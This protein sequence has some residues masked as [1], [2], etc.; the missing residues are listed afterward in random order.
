M[1]SFTSQ[2]ALVAVIVG[3]ATAVAVL[4]RDRKPLSLRY[5]AFSLG[6][7]L[8]FLVSFLRTLIRDVDFDGWHMASASLVLVGGTAF[9]QALLSD[10]GGRAARRGRL[11]WLVA[12]VL[13]VLAATPLHSHL[14]I[15]VAAAVLAL[16]ILGSLVWTMERRARDVESEVERWRLRTVTVG[17]VVVLGAVVVDLVTGLGVPLPPPGGIATAIYLYFMSQSLVRRRLLDLHEL[18]AKAAVFSALALTLAAVY[19]VLVLWASAPGVFVFNTL[20]ASAI[21]LI[22]YDPVRA[23]LEETF[24]RTFFA[25]QRDFARTLAQQSHSLLSLVDAEAVQTR[26]LDT[27]YNSKRA[28]HCAFYLLG[29]S[30]LGLT[31]SSFR[32]PRP[33]NRLE[34]GLERVLLDA[35]QADRV[36]LQRD[37]LQDRLDGH[38]LVD[39]RRAQSEA[40]RPLLE[41][42]DAMFADLVIPIV[43]STRAL[44]LLTLRDERIESAFSN[45]EITQL[46]RV[47]DLVAVALE[48]SRLVERL[49]ERD[50]LA[51]LGEMAAG[52]AHE[53][54]NPLGAIKSTV[55]YLEP[56][57]ARDETRQFYDIILSE[58]N[59]LERV[60]SQFLDYA[61][62]SSSTFAPF[63]LNDAIQRTLTLLQ[64]S[65]IP[66]AVT[67]ELQLADALPRVSGDIDQLRQ[68]ILNLVLNAVQAMRGSGRLSVHT[69]HVASS[70]SADDGHV[71]L[72]VGDSG[73]GIAPEVRARLFAPFFSTREGGTGLG[74]AIC[75]RIIE[76]HGGR[77]GVRSKPGEGAEFSVHLPVNLAVRSERDLGAAPSAEITPAA[78]SPVAA[79]A[80]SPP[81][82]EDT[83]TA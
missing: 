36:P 62:P 50:R 9:F 12:L 28:T 33:V 56:D 60:V 76:S 25:R 38:A 83:A 48:N 2:A 10:H 45:D 22:L 17:G 54:R 43:G 78:G 52:L 11:A 30:D 72:R 3:V 55:Q 16:S 69:E 35:V 65:E 13:L 21:I 82:P 49:R 1:F 24:A 15:R 27:I 70:M 5:A 8:F 29:D 26:V 66:E 47:A 57:L 20:L 31:L 46:V 40:T 59:R 42:L 18:L 23:W 53:I 74:L 61:R 63:D 75:K 80:A 41:A 71:V 81:K 77:I 68:V 19:G 32:G 64:G 4:I 39:G 37:T 34:P 6:A 51:L 58:V 14:A 73:A 7:A 44:G 67:V 79:V